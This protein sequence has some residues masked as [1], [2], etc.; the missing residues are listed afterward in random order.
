[1]YTLLAWRN[2]WRNPRRTLIVLTA[3]VIGVG[4]MV[5]LGALMRGMVA[6]MVEN[7]I[8]NLTGH[9]RIQ[10]RAYRSDPSI[11]HRITN[12]GA[13]ATAALSVLP[14]GTRAVFRLRVDAVVA[15]SR[16]TTGVVLV[17]IHPAAEHGAS[18]I[19]AA[20]VDGR[21]ISDGDANVILMGRALSDTLETGVG[22][23][24]VLMSQGADG[25][26]ASRAFR[27]RGVY[28]AEMAATEKAFVFAPLA[29][30]QRMLGV[31]G[32]VTEI[33]FT[34]PG[35]DAA[36][37]DLAPLVA[38][39]DRQ[40]ASTA[41]VA[42]SWQDML[43]AVSAYLKLF[44]GFMM[45]WYLVVFV[46]MGFG[47]VNTVLMA[48]YERM[49]E[50]GLLKALGMRPAR[51]FRMV[52]GETLM[53]LFMGMTLGNLIAL[54]GIGL[55]SRGGIDLSVFARGAEMWGISRV[56]WPVVTAPDFLMANV[57]VLGLGLLVGVYPALRA[58]RFTPIET[59]RQH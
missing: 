9:L 11:A 54:G 32:A 31:G 25:D 23:K 14:E 49:R 13:L 43:P 38:A 40:L 5:L 57:T 56:I 12:P 37:T 46:A 2:L 29:T 41:L 36:Q 7:A 19:G 16:E 48:V 8:D 22:R 45:I 58:A 55:L 52:L 10:D 53:L 20:P 28:H 3:V 42:E 51:I 24:I 18:F 21:M 47:L 17:G 59:M 39:L 26:I 30:V 44:D 34:L 27:V 4:S 6:G 33:A 1:M 35:K 15:T 50:F